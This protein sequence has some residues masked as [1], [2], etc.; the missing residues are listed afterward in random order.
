MH[1]GLSYVRLW[2][3]SG[4]P[5]G[6]ITDYGHLLKEVRW[7]VKGHGLT[8]VFHIGAA[9]DTAPADRTAGRSTPQPIKRV[10]AVMDLLADMALPLSVGWT[11]EVGNPVAAPNNVSAAWTVDDGSIINLTDNGDGTARAAATGTLGQAIVHLEVSADGVPNQTG[12]L[13]IVVV[14]GLAE[15]AEIVPGEPEEVTP[16]A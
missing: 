16:D 10:D 2:G 1:A 11:D 15:R 9:R 13:L 4:L 8:A 6:K 3:V 12:D 7:L 5:R 14:P